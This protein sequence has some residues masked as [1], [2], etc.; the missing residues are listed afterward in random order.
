MGKSCVI[1]DIGDKKVMFDCGV[2][3]GF[4][5]KRRIPDFSKIR[6]KGSL[7]DTIDCVIITHL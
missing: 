4:T 2:H 6:R 7:T 5:D 1:T 3:M